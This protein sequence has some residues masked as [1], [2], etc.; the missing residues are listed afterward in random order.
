MLAHSPAPLPITISYAE[1][2]IQHYPVMSAEDERNALLAISHR[3]RVRRIA[4]SCIAIALFEKFVAA[5]E[6]EFPI[7]ERLYLAPF[8]CSPSEVEINLT[9]PRTFQAPNLH[10]IHLM[11]VTFPT[12]SPWLTT[13]G[14]LRR[15]WLD[16]I[17]ETAY[18]P[19]SY[20]VAHLSLMP[21]L[22]T[23]GI[24]FQS[25]LPHPADTAIVTHVTLPNLRLIFFH[26][27]SAYLDGLLARITTPF[28]S[29]LNVHSVDGLTSVIPWLFQFM[30]PLEN[31]M[32]SDF[33]LAFG[34]R[35]IRLEADP[36]RGK[37]KRP[38]TLKM[39]CR[40]NNLQV[41]SVVQILRTLAPLLS[42]VEQLTLTRLYGHSRINSIDL[43]QWHELL[44]SFGNVKVLHVPKDFIGMVS[45]VLRSE[46]GE[47]PPQLL[48]N[49][50]SITYF[51]KNIA[52]AIAP[53]IHERQAAGH[54]VCVKLRVDGA[55]QLEG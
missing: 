14:G 30:E 29:T 52:K 31:L 1:F 47:P 5:M 17:P 28:L 39:M 25:D 8:L 45:R 36:H 4:I 55:S 23:L 13:M 38:F 22:E 20:I 6:E 34:E 11:G 43:T 50:E 35:C 19:P 27:V 40:Q 32:F 7:L 21:Q 41:S 49:L 48:P 24:S 18:F 26:G 46:D 10:H 12:R 51:E 44:R 54:P 2:Q 9:L 53:L 3:D 33:G 15:L 37:W 16:G 42:A